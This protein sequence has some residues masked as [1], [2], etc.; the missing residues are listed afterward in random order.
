MRQPSLDA[1]IAK[2][3]LPALVLVLVR[4]SLREIPRDGGEAHRDPKLLEFG[5]NLPRAPTVLTRESTNEGLYLDG[6]GRSS[7]PSFRNESPVQSEAFSV[8]ADNGV[9]LD[10]DQG[11][12]PT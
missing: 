7:R 8:P 2:E 4:V 9:G 10:D 1:L 11:F 12:F 6:N 3:G 5:L